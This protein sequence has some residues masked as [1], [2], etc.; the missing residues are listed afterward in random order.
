MY[1]IASANR[2]RAVDRRG[3]VQLQG[4]EQELTDD[5]KRDS[6][7]SAL[8]RIEQQIL[9]EPDKQARR[10]LGKRKLKLQDLLS[11]LK[12][13]KRPPGFAWFFVTAAREHLRKADFNMISTRAHQLVAEWHAEH[14]EGPPEQGEG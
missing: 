13:E 10:V 5:Q 11:S 2:Q 12:P 9:S 4:G 1:K 3:V 8:W 14:G 6:A 7:K